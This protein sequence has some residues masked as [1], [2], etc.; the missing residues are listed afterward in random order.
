MR[1]F[2]RKNCREKNI[3]LAGAQTHEIDYFRA[4]LLSRMDPS[5]AKLI[6][7]QASIKNQN[8]LSK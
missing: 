8:V 7:A 3:S 2:K 4:G 1:H 5:Y 6:L